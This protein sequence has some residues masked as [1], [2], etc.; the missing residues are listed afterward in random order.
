[1]RDAEGEYA[2][3]NPANSSTTGEWQASVGSI[4][5]GWTIGAWCPNARGDMVKTGITLD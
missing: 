1:M 2:T 4:Q 5:A 3:A